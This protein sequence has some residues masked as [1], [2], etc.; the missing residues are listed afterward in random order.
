[1]TRPRHTSWGVYTLAILVGVLYVGGW[2]L[3]IHILS[4]L[5]GSQ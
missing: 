5:K 2:L 1:V 4:I 3:F